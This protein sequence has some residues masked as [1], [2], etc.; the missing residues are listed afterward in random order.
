M[1][2]IVGCNKIY[3]LHMLLY[4]YKRPHDNKP[5][6]FCPLNSAIVMF[7]CSYAVHKYT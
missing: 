4:L 7:Y 2:K 5:E 3:F 6:N 1:K